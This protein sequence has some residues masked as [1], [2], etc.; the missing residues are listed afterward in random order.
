MFRNAFFSQIQVDLSDIL[1]KK[2]LMP[3]IFFYS[4][5]D[6]FSSK[7]EISDEM[8]YEDIYSILTSKLSWSAL[9][10]DHISFNFL[11]AMSPLNIN[12]LCLIIN[13]C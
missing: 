13:T 6:T 11:K 8:L 3:H 10:H 5:A 9:D 1:D 12:A 7:L 4:A 2:I